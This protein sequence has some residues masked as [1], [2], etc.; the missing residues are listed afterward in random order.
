ME[1]TYE[2]EIAELDAQIAAVEKLSRDMKKA[3]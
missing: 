1:K 2:E 3:A